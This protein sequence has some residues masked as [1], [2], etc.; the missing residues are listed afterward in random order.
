MSLRAVQQP[1][2]FLI[3]LNIKCPDESNQHKTP[4]SQESFLSINLKGNVEK[5]IMND[6]L[7]FIL[8]YI[9]QT[10]YSESVCHLS[11]ITL[12]IP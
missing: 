8:N 3:R 9:E 5:K 2:S 7:I 4:Y 10:M 1:S 12:K 6:Y 11:V